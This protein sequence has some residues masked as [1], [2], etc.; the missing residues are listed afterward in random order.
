MVNYD[1][2]FRSF[3]IIPKFTGVLSM[4]GSTLLARHI[5]TKK[6][7]GDV[8]LTNKILFWIS[9]VDII[10]SFFVYFFTPWNAGVFICSRNNRHLLCT[11]VLFRV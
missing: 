2:V 7:W 4:T 6:K 3:E 9:I 1:N 5:I 8:S 10:D 11:R